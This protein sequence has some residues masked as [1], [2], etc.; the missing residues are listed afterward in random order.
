MKKIRWQ[1][2]V[3]SL[4]IISIFIVKEFGV[5]QIKYT[6]AYVF[7]DY[8]QTL[9]SL[10]KQ[11]NINFIYKVNDTFIDSPLLGK[12]LT[13]KAEQISDYELSRYSILLPIIFSKYPEIIIKKDIKNIKLAHSLT[14]FGV[15]YGGTS[16]G[17]TLYLTSLG[18]SNGYTDSYIEEL[19]HH[20]FSSV[21]M[22]KYKFNAQKFS[23][24]N[25][26]GFKYAQNVDDI[27]R[28]ITQDTSTTGND[29]LYKNGFLTRYSMSTLENDVN[30]YAEAIFTKPKYLRNLINNYP[31]INKKYLVMK[32]FYLG[33]NSDFSKI[34]DI[35]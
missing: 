31:V 1:I 25:P 3:V 26:H 10:G 28:A 35:I 11:Y 4:I 23:S 5:N 20:E 32:Q 19:F 29:T 30:V 8:K 15:S 16:I 7:T 2:A 14:L 27:L 24:Y 21:L 17:N 6:Y 22:R 34:F 18:Y 12:N 9:N 33:I 13:N